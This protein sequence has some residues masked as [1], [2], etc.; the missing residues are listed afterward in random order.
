MQDGNVVNECAITCGN[1]FDDSLNTPS[2]KSFLYKYSQRILIRSFKKNFKEI[3]FH[4]EYML[5]AF[6]DSVMIVFKKM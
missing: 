1:I 3:D 5:R 2:C 4:N 6:D